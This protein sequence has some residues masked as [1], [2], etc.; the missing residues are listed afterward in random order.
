M[1]NYQGGRIIIG[2]NDKTGEINPLSFKETQETTQALGNIAS[3]M[4]NPSILI[5]TDSSKVEGG[6]LVIASIKEGTNKPY[7]DNK[8]IFWIK[9]GSDKRKIFDNMELRAMMDD[10]GTFE[11]DEAVVPDATMDDMDMDAITVFLLKKYRDALPKQTD[12]GRKPSDLSADEIASLLIKDKTAAD[13]LK[14]LKLIR[15]DGRFT[16]AAVILFAKVTQRFLPTYTAKCISF[17][18]N[19]IGGGEY[20]DRFSDTA[21]EGNILHQ[22]N[23]IMQFFTRNLRNVQVEENFNSLG[24]LEIP[25]VALMEFTANALVHRSLVWTMPVRV[26]IFDDRVE[27]H[28]PGNLPAGMTVESMVSGVS[29]PRNDLLFNNAIFLLPYTGAGSGLKRAM[30]TGIEVQFSDNEKTKEFVVTIPRKEH[31]VN[32]PTSTKVHRVSKKQQDILNFCSIPRTAQEIMDR[33][34]IQN[35]SR[36]RKRYIQTLIDAGQLERTIPE[37]PNDPNQKYRRVRK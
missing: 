27:I 19:S 10:C 16:V 22:Y 9:Q 32:A 20:H 29:M 13:I 4:L 23:S 17:F 28:S 35:Q 11:A 2:I 15:P 18:G 8:G 34:G 21:M 14:N 6:N 31:H 3:T 37:N 36:S 33:L 30:D 26:F 24:E 12:D 7:H 1:S 25:P 5:E